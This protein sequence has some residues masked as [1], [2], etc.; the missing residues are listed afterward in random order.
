LILFQTFQGKEAHDRRHQQ[1]KSS[2]WDRSDNVVPQLE[3]EDE[4]FKQQQAKLVEKPVFVSY[5]W[6]AHLYSKV[7]VATNRIASISFRTR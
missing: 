6:I 4:K 1:E 5:F 7:L 2:R 3:T